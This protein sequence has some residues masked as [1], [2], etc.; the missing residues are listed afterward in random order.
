MEVED[1]NYSHCFNLFHGNPSHC[2]NLFQGNPSQIDHFNSI[3]LQNPHDHDHVHDHYHYHHH[4]PSVVIDQEKRLRR[5]I[6]NRE[7]AKRS[8]MRKRKQIEELQMQLEQLMASNQHLSDKVFSLL[9]NNRQ[10][11][12]ENSQLKET[13]SSFHQYFTENMMIVPGNIYDF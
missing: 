9:E 7:S 5:T 10:I 6:S 12:Q 13:V 1:Q 4:Q 8:R 3:F 11:L 2:F